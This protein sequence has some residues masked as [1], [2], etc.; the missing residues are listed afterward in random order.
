MAIEYITNL[1]NISDLHKW[2]FWPEQVK[3]RQ[4][5]LEKKRLEYYA[6][7]QDKTKPWSQV[8]GLSERHDQEYPETDENFKLLYYKFYILSNVMLGY[9]VAEKLIR[10]GKGTWEHYY[11][12]A[13]ELAVD[14]SSTLDDKIDYDA[15][16][17]A[18][19]YIQNYLT[20]EAGLS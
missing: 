7:M 5:L 14:L 11:I 6:R 2:V 18:C 3:E 1:M 19:E 12:P 17:S 10:N 20:G 4:Q 16:D 9:E 13:V 8:L 15:F